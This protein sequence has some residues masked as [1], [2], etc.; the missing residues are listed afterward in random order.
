MRRSWGWARSHLQR[1]CARRAPVARAAD[2]SVEGAGGSHRSGI[3]PGARRR[4]RWLA[5]KIRSFVDSHPCIGLAQMKPRP[6]QNGSYRYSGFDRPSATSS[7]SAASNLLIP[8]AFRVVATVFDQHLLVTE[9]KFLALGTAVPGLRGD[10]ASA[11]HVRWRCRRSYRRRGHSKIFWPA[12]IR[13]L[14]RLQ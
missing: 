4:S 5:R 10:M 14:L 11:E 3:C 8:V 2:E 13:R 6:N 9:R 7:L 12:M 1:R